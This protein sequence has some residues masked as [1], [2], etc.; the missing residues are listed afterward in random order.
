MNRVGSSFKVRKAGQLLAGYQ[1][2]PLAAS[3]KGSGSQRV[4][5][6]NLFIQPTAVVPLSKMAMSCSLPVIFVVCQV[7]HCDR[8]SVQ[9]INMVKLRPDYLW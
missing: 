3:R 2:E 5:S 1:F 6:Y 7:G 4:T 8:I 9:M